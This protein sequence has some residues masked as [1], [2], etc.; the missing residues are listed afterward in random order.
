MDS[1]DGG[2]I[3]GTSLSD[4]HRS[5]RIHRVHWRAVIAKT[6]SSTRTIMSELMMPND[7][8]F[9]GKVFGGRL[10]SLIDLCAYT[11]AARFSGE[12]CVT[13]SMDR[14][15]FIAPIDVGDFVTME[16]VVSSV[17][18]TSIEVTI[19]V[20]AENPLRQEER[21]FTNNARLTMVAMRDGKPTPVPRLI[22]ETHEDKVRYIQGRKRSILRQEYRQ[23]RE[24][25]F[26]SIAQASDEELDRMLA[27]VG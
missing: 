4:V 21:R 15:D 11:C 26:D 9:L 23:E 14:V 27:E 22:F 18:R 1:A 3:F 10:V 19:D 7:A 12:A 17:G 25:L 24:R 8:N 16:A 2:S 13:A 5:R 6:V 20:Y